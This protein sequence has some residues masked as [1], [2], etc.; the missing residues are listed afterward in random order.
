VNVLVVDDSKVERNYL[1]GLL[2]KLGISADVAENCG[3]GVDKCCEKQ[4]DLIFIDYFMPDADGVH[5]LKEI[6]TVTGTRNSDTPAVALGTADPVLGDDFF[7]MQ[8]FVNYLEKPVDHELLHASLLLY[9]SEMKRAELG[10]A[11]SE[12]EQAD[13]IIPGWLRGIEELDTEAGVKNCGS[14]EGYMSALGI[15]YNS[16]DNMSHEIQSYYDS[17]NLIDYTI[18]V[19]A[20]KS[21]A[22]IIGLADLSELAKSLEAAGDSGDM[23][24]IN[25]ETENLLTWYRSYKQKLARLSGG[26]EDSDKPPAEQEFLEDAFSSLEEFAGQMDYDMV[27][28]VINSVDE[29]KLEPEDQEIFDAVNDAFMSLDWNRLKASAHRYIDRIY[30]NTDSEDSG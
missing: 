30:G 22:R 27:E 28:M 18:K 11:L 15:F 21:S 5:A 4:Y 26:G 19:H 29:Y 25:N 24:M 23:D 6:R 2:G 1:A 17:G 10:H 20:L 14:E 3:T 7:V 16:I 8:G 12:A 9:L 13:S